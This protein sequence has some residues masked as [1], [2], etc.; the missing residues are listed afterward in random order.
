M[1]Q[2]ILTNVT[3]KVIDQARA[4]AESINKDLKK[5]D[6]TIAQQKKTLSS[7]TPQ[8]R[9]AGA[10]MTA[11]GGA[12]AYSIA[13]L[14]QGA[15][16]A[17]GIESAFNRFFGT[18][19]PAALKTLQE[20]T[21]NTV[22]EV[23]LMKQANQALLLGID[24]NALPE[25]FKGAFAAASAT[26]RP[27]ADAIN[28]ITVGIG[29][30]SKL[31]LDNLGIIVNAE[32]ANEKMARSLGKTS[33]ALTDNERKIAFTN[34]TMDAL[35]KNAERIGEVNDNAAISM[36]RAGASMANAFRNLGDSFAPAVSAIAEKV[37]QIADAFNR[38]SP[39]TRKLIGQIILLGTAF[40][41][42]GGVSLLAISSIGSVITTLTALTG[43]VGVAVRALRTLAP[44]MLS[45]GRMNISTAFT[46]AA[47]GIGK[48]VVALRTAS[49]AMLT[50]LANPVVLLLA[51]IAA[52]G[53]AAY[54][55]NQKI[56]AAWQATAD[57]AAENTNR[58]M[59]TYDNWQE[60]SKNLTGNEQKYAR[61]RIRM[62]YHMA[63]AV[64][65]SEAQIE[66]YRLGGSEAAIAGFQQQMDFHNAKVAEMGQKA[67][68]FQKSHKVNMDK[69]K[70][71]YAAVGAAAADSGEEQAAGGKKAEDAVKK[72]REAMEE[73]GRQYWDVIVEI[74]RRLL[75]LKTQHRDAMESMQKD[76]DDTVESITKLNT[77]YQKSLDEMVA[78]HNEA[79]DDLTGDRATSLV[80]Q[81][82][83]VK[84]LQQQIADFKYKPDA[85][86]SDRLINVIENRQ[87]KGD[88]LAASD[89]QAFGLTG[90]QVAQVNAV[91]E[92]RKQQEALVKVLKDNYDISEDLGKSL[93]N[94]YG[95]AQLDV[96]G[97]I[98]ASL[99]DLKKA[100][101]FE[102]LTDIEQTF[103][104]M[105]EQQTDA[106]ADLKKSQE[107]A[108]VRYDEELKALQ[109][110]R[111]EI[112]ENMRKAEEAYTAERA[113]LLKTKI[114]M[115]EFSTDYI[116]NLNNVE[117]VTDDKL[118]SMQSKLEQ[119]R[120]TIQSI[121]A[122][123]QRRAD[124]TGGG[125]IT[126]AAQAPRHAKGGVFSSPHLGWVAEAG[127]PE[128]IIPLEGGAVP[129]KIS[130]GGKTGNV[131]HI[132]VDMSGMTVRGDN[133]PQQIAETVVS[134]LDNQLLKSR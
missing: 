77:E 65:L 60:A 123:L 54:I 40:S 79:M 105:A 35:R 74:N 27:V 63:E 1:S 68:D 46:T 24:P 96:I 118:K 78:E 3:I 32:A 125:S 67:L 132:T 42:I 111:A 38:L 84:D 11:V 7:L 25:M 59:T 19:A 83:K 101:D 15:G 6:D 34:A 37:Q 103:A 128:A 29:R 47:A 10:A 73:L 75:D 55:M 91:L 45:I 129:V 121:D 50:F 81:F 116:S 113:E 49:A 9:A 58:V 127:R 133:S 31:I 22:S 94:T 52:I 66:Q 87:V 95:E 134:A 104:R 62:A 130:G 53:V 12:A 57:S 86:N 88:T 8:L 69:V 100:Q 2:N 120:S 21:R 56:D 72:M 98:I 28:D 131:Y 51:G 110:R 33:A 20:A 99:D 43:T 92:Y 70:G 122:L 109:D 16:Q 76:L 102:G 80:Q 107:D 114:A 18:T 71:A 126:Q 26:G 61:I 106:E 89:A 64:R 97:K 4:A 5:L 90:D 17:A 82:E 14:A 119:L 39:E 41:L 13:K 30:Q 23:D 85:L 112:E 117:K 115:Q 44:V 108:K 48:M 36:Q 124:I 93:K